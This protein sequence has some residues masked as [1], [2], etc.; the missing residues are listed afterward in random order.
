MNLLLDLLDPVNC[1]A[2]QSSTL[3]TLVTVLLDQP[4]NTRTFEDLD[5]LLTVTSLFKLRATSREVKLKLVE[6]LYFYLMPEIPSIPMAGASAPNTAVLG[7]Q[8]SPSKLASAFTRSV[9]SAADNRTSRE[10]R[11]TEE[12]QRLL[13]RY[14]SNVEDL[15]EDLKETAPF[16]GTVY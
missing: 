2:I 6:F 11:T 8:R 9:N 3:L 15:V 14:L 10:T 5:G 1:P 16:G 13:G 4:V 7:L 12:K